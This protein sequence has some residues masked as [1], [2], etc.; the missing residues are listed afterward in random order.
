MLYVVYTCMYSMHIYI[1]TYILFLWYKYKEDFK[2][3][4]ASNHTDESQLNV[5]KL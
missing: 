1:H 4:E 2:N 3:L 5:P